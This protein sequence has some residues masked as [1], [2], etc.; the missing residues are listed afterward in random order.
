MMQRPREIKSRS[1]SAALSATRASSRPLFRLPISRFSG[2]S[3]KPLLRVPLETLS[4][5]LLPAQ[6]VQGP[7][8]ECQSRQST[9]L[10]ASPATDRPSPRSGLRCCRPFLLPVFAP[11]LSCSA[12]SPPIKIQLIHRKPS[13]NAALLMQ[14]GPV[15]PLWFNGQFFAFPQQPFYDKD[16]L[17]LWSWL[18]FMVQSL[19]LNYKSSEGRVC[20][21]HNP[22][23]SCRR[24]NK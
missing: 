19:S 22:L 6:Q 13:S 9:F 23:T 1:S 15:L 11:V 10:P 20:V 3:W 12:S 7:C 17:L 21:P 2:P 8:R 5:S 16:C 14:P 24:V 18:V 4:G